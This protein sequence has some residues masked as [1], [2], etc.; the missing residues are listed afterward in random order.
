MTRITDPAERAVINGL[1]GGFPLSPRPF[2][3]VGAR[4]GLD[5][6]EM[7]A[8]L[9]RLVESGRASRFG[10]LWNAEGI[11]G[12]VCLCAMAV[13]PERFEEVTEAVNAHPE[14][15]H[16]YERT[17]RL[18]MWFV[19]SAERPERIAE[20][21]AEI[22]AETGLQVYPMPKTREFFIDFRLEV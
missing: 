5:E 8:T 19:L 15:A 22:E 9:G 3:E 7:L 17:H 13:P 12:A 20:V 21:Q 6:A 18:N 1:Q 14:V 16:N 2:A 4:F 10:P 11:G